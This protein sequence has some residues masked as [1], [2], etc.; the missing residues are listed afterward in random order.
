MPMPNGGLITE[1][2]RQYYEGAQG[3]Q[4]DNV[5]GQ[6]SFTTTFNTNLVS[7]GI[8]AWDPSDVNYPLN[9]FK[10]YTSAT[11]YPGTF[12]EYPQ[13]LS[14]TA[15]FVVN[16]NTITTETAIPDNYYVVIQLKILTGGN[17]GDKDAY[18]TTVEQN[19]GGYQY[20]SLNDVINSFMVAYVGNG[21]LIPDVKR[22]DVI[23]HAKRAMQE[24]SYD[25]LK[26]IKSQ[27]LTIPH[28]LSVVL[29]QDYVNYVGMYWIDRQSVK[30]PIYPANNLTSNPSEAPLQD[31]YGVEVQDNFDSNI[32]TEPIIEERWR[33]AN[34]DMLNGTYLA[35]SVNYNNGLDIYDYGWDN[36]GIVGRQYG[37][38]PQFAQGNGW[39]TINDREGKVSFSSNLHKM[40]IT[41]DYISDG[42]AYDLDTRVPKMA[43]EA[44]YAY[45]LHA[46]VATRRD[47]PEYLVQ[48]LNR[49]KF[50]KLRNTKIRLSTIKLHEIV[51]VMRGK[52]KWIKH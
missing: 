11:G 2:N 25:T 20:T 30:H 24:F 52:S 49:E 41:L 38:D 1:T 3:F 32:D 39:F 37:L 5:L 28:S 36:F 29:P 19:Y 44:M 31:D 12:L 48:R 40:I 17:Y 9:N 6:S 13:G 8:N 46:I 45:I 47:S 7:G 22:T 34:T 16:D 35:N 14:G 4:V 33:R 10:L 27:E 21:K 18:G 51:Q 15:G 42:L 43:E 23:F 26:S 50:A